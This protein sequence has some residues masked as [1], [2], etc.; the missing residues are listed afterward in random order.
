MI[1]KTALEIVTHGCF[2]CFFRSKHILI[3]L[4]GVKAGAIDT[5]YNVL[6]TAE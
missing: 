2:T 4:F 5:G 3:G 1:M 6:G